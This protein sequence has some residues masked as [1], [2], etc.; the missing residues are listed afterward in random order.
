MIR[1]NTTR[2]DA[3]LIDRIAH[4]ATRAGLLLTD[5]LSLEMDLTATH[6]N[7]CALDLARL[8][9]ADDFNF[10]HD[11]CGIQRHL[12]RKTGG[13]LRLFRPRCAVPSL[14]TTNAD[15]EVEVSR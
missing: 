5:R 10:A 15:G 2:R 11:V 9:E 6:L 8:L 14:L 13:L 7:G 4:R 12:D 1:F 3:M